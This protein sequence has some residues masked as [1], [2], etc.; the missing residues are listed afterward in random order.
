VFHL[1]NDYVSLQAQHFR[2]Q[3][4]VAGQQPGGTIPKMLER[5]FL[6]LFTQHWREVMKFE[7]VWSREPGR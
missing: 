4:R 2:V 7:N 5:L 6:Q 1:Q 3:K